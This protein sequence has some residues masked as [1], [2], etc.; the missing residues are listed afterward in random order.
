MLGSPSGA[1][2]DSFGLWAVKPPYKILNIVKDTD[3]PGDQAFDHV[4]NYNK[5]HTSFIFWQWLSIG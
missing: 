1:I 5:I 2:T 4:F 3:F